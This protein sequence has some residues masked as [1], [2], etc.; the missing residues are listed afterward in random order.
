MDS[1]FTFHAIIR[2]QSCG[3]LTGLNFDLCFQ[4]RPQHLVGAPLLKTSVP[5]ADAAIEEVKHKI[6]IVSI[7]STL[8]IS[9]QTL[10]EEIIFFVIV[11]CLP[12]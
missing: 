1:N 12:T 10:F 2:I 6:L 11:T 8:N 9:R 7:H 4:D 5:F 3:E